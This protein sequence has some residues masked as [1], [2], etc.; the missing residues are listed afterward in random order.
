MYVTKTG[1]VYK[2]KPGPR[3]IADT[4]RGRPPGSKNKKKYA[5]YSSIEELLKATGTI[6]K[7]GRGRPKGSKNKPRY[8]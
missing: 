3:G 4:R 8:Y 5:G 1:R 7:R 6:K 2:K